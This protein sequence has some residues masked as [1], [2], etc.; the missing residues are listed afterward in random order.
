MTQASATKAG[1]TRVW[2]A[3]ATGVLLA[4]PAYFAVV[5]IAQRPLVFPAPEVPA[6]A[7]RPHDALQV[8]LNSAAGRT[9]AWYLP[10]LKGGSGATPLIIYFHGNA[11]LIDLLPSEFDVPR[12]WGMGVLLVEFPGYG[13]SSGAPS[14]VA[15]SAVALAA[16]DWL[17]THTSIDPKRVVAFGRSLGGATAVMLAVERP[18]AALIL[19]S[20][21]ASLR[22]IVAGFGV[23]GFA[24][25]DP[26][27]S[28]ARIGSYAGPVLVLHGV[29][30]E[31]IPVN[32][33][34][35]LA[36]TA[37]RGEFHTIPGGHNDCVRPWSVV[38][39]FL[40]KNGV[41]SM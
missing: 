10:P 11:E 33:G 38:R 19:E 3:I 21:F 16:Y 27:D 26:F 40:E 6:G 14:E 1:V 2:R 4:A 35:L 34:R 36:R 25:L 20:T 9:E 8:W 30:D 17:P 15:I 5:L 23:P 31:L 24:A 7:S 32:D 37:R 29:Q 13:R 22:G 12:G 28:V 18:T 39:R 41:L